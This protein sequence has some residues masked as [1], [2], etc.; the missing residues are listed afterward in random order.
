MAMAVDP[1]GQ[2][3]RRRSTPELRA[4]LLAA[5]RVEFGTKGFANTTSRDVAQ[6]AGVAM[7]ALYRH[8]DT[9]ADLFSEAVLEPFVAGFEKLGDDWMRQLDEPMDDA[10]LMRVFLRDVYG[11]LTANQHALDA[12]ISSRDELPEAMTE[13]IRSAFDRLITQLRVMTEL[14]ARRRGWMSAEGIDMSVRVLIGMVMGMS[15][16]GWLLLPDGE[17][18]SVDAEVIEGM[19]KLGLWGMTRMREGT[20]GAPAA[21]ADGE[22]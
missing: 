7:S 19:I 21:W 9:K 16:H 3:Q 17:P 4:L 1:G 5:A 10:D 22:N 14:E 6:R 8:F 2:A 11:T 13:R 12:L 15:S 20:S 18:E